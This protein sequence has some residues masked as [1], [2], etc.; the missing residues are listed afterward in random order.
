[1]PRLYVFADEAGCLEFSRGRNVSKYFILCTVSLKSCAVGHSLQELRRELA[2]R[3]MELGDYFHATEDKQAVRDEVFA[4]ICQH[5]FRIQ[6]LVM[7]KSKAQPH[8][9][10][11]RARFYQYGWYYHFKHVAPKILDANSEIMVTTASIGTKK[12]R[13]SFENAVDDVMKQTVRNRA[14]WATNFC[15]AAAEP[16]LQVADYC[17]WAIQRKWERNDTRSYDLIKDR[18][19]HEYDLWQ[20]GTQHYY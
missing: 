3:K 9:R 20:R 4:T 5:D 14:G 16:C 8:V 11:S 10:S 6:A 12:E 1:V 19:V 17:A 13:A 2:W 15:P 7:E 18:M